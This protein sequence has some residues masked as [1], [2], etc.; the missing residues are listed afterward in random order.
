MFGQPQVGVFRVFLTVM[1]GLLLA[2]LSLPDWLR[3]IRPDFLLLFVIYWSLSGPQFTGLMFA[4]FCGLLVDLLQGMVLGEHALAFVVVSY[5]T[6]RR[7]LSL[8]IYP[9][10]QQA[11]AVLL[12]LGVYRFIIFYI[13]GLIGAPVTSW[14]SWVPILTGA[15]SWPLIVASFDTWMRP[16][17]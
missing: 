9:V 3:M 4:W 12:F 8:R 7:Q 10:W 14:H 5:L 17:R 11:V 13:D 15:L 6:H 2:L 16:R 1:V